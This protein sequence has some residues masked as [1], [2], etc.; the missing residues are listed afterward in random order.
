[1]NL[2]LALIW[3]FVGILVGAMASSWLN[4][5][6]SRLAQL[7]ARAAATESQLRRT[8]EQLR[9]QN[10]EL[11]AQIEA[12]NQ[13]H[14]RATESL[15]LDLTSQRTA[16]EEQLARAQQKLDLMVDLAAQGPDV[17]DTAFEPTQFSE[18]T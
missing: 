2:I 12:Q 3:L 1:M 17:S 7:D 14:V 11:V 10:R 13:R 15:K 6:R 8:V 16:L 4:P 18:P 5:S 9:E